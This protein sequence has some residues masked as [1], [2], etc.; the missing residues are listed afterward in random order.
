M[1]M[2]IW[3][4]IPADCGEQGSTLTVF[5]GRNEQ[6]KMT[7]DVHYEQKPGNHLKIIGKVEAKV[8]KRTIAASIQMHSECWKY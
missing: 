1:S 4:K 7:L 2:E 5:E 8:S 3:E 6:I